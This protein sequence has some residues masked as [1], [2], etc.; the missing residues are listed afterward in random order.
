MANN[1]NIPVDDATAEKMRARYYRRAK[2]ILQ[3]NDDP[4]TIAKKLSSLKTEM[5]KTILGGEYD[6]EDEDTED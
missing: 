3:D 5:K 4:K 6:G 1:K 2:E